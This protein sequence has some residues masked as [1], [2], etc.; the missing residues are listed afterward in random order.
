MKTF[1]WCILLLIFSTL[2]LV[3]QS[4]FKGAEIKEQLLLAIRQKVGNEAEIALP[5]V[6]SDYY[7]PQK[8]VYYEFDFG[9]QFPSGNILVGLEFWHN[10]GKVRRVEIPVRIKL[11]QE[12][13]IAKVPINKGEVISFDNCS[14]EKKEL[15]SK[16]NPND[17]SIEYAVGKVAKYNIVR[18][19]IVSRELVQEPFAI[20]RGEKVRIVVLSGSVRVETYGIALNDANSGEQVRVRQD[21]NGNVVV[22]LASADGCV[23]VTK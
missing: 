12:V 18:G 5:N 11:V 15:P 10:G 14:I 2:D 4:F 19:A 6:I 9:T 21:R 7:F 3:S 13:L 23:V 8:D 22:G 1:W 20:R 17:V 16:L